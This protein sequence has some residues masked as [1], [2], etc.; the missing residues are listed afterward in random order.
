LHAFDVARGRAV[1]GVHVAAADPFRARRNTD[2]VAAAIVA[3][4]VPAVCVP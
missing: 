3:D 2:P 1:A 4:E